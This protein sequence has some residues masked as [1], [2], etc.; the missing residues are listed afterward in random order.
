[1]N[2]LPLEFVYNRQTDKIRDIDDI[3]TIEDDWIYITNVPHHI[4]RL[5]DRI[6]TSED[7]DILDDSIFLAIS[8]YFRDNLEVM[9]KKI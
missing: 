5:C 7:F 8:A 1:M 3:N 2:S 6:V 9:S 4:H